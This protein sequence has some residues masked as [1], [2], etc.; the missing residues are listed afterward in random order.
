VYFE[1]GDGGGEGAWHI[2]QVWRREAL[3]AGNVIHG[4][5]AIE[6]VSATSILYP[7]DRAEVLASGN[8]I[9]EV[10]Q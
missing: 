7:G 2:A 3:L 9:V 8:I 10:A 5:A 6:E 4:P 1:P